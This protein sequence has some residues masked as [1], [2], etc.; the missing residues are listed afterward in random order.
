MPG[1]GFVQIPMAGAA[2]GHDNEGRNRQGGYRSSPTRR[3]RAGSDRSASAAR[4]SRA[5]RGRARANARRARDRFALAARSAAG[6]TS[7]RG[8]LTGRV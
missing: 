2:A 8:A 5:S 3:T 7:A 4:G 6:A 1:D